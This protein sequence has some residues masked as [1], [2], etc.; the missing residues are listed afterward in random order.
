MYA[1]RHKARRQ[2]GATIITVLFLVTALA[3]LGTFMWRTQV[4]TSRM[5]TTEWD[6]A[7][8]LY[9]AESGVQ[10]AAWRAWQGQTGNGTGLDGE[11]GE[12]WFDSSVSSQ[13]IG[14]RTL[15]TIEAT[16]RAGTSNAQP[17]AERRLRV[18]FFE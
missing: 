1:T 10:W 16:G 7:R 6:S 15:V 8:A 5:T 14:S 9:A 2:D 18:Q 4:V 17:A 13:A 12:S 11:N 3:A